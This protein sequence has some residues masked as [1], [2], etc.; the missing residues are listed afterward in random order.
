MSTSSEQKP[1][2]N[3]LLVAITRLGD[4]LQASPTIVGMKE[5]F[6]GARLT[7]L[8]DQQFAAICR[9]IPGIDE[10]Y[11]VDLSM[12]VRSLH[13]EGEG[14]VDGFAYVQ[15]LV[16][17][18][19]SR[20]FDY[21]VNMASA[22]YTALLVK[23]LD[24]EQSRGWTADDE[25]QRIISN[26]WSM[27]FAA[28]VY[29]SNRHYNSINLVDVIR[30]SAGVHAHPRHLVY[31][32]PDK[33]AS[34]PD[35]FLAENGI[36]DGSGPLVC[37][38]AGASQEKRQWAPVKFARLLQLLVEQHGARVIMTGA[39]SEAQIIERILS[40]Y[41][42]PNIANAVGKTNLGELAALLKRADALVTGDTG[43]MHLSVAVGTPVVALFLA[44]A[45]CFETGPYSQGN[46][47]IQPQISCN[48]CNPNF[49]CPRPDCH[50]Q[51]TPDMVAHL[52]ELRLN[53][54]SDQVK[55]L[56]VDERLCPAESV[57]IYYSDFDEE[58]FLDFKRI[59]SPAQRLGYHP[60]YF[61]AAM[62]AYRQL[63]KEEFGMMEPK[64][65]PSVEPLN[66]LAVVDHRSE[67]TAGLE[68]AVKAAA[69][70]IEVSER[71]IELIRDVSSSPHLL[72]EVNNQINAINRHIEDIGLT[73]PM[74]GALVRMFVMERQ[75]MQGKDAALL[76]LDMKEI[77]ENL[78][79]RGQKFAKLFKY[80]VEQNWN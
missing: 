45:Y 62:D 54:P 3:I 53:T 28:F 71:L 34:F 12:V 47:V 14:I 51:I 60:G 72:G 78:R 79:R 6:P 24:I 29:H 77:Y 27:L 64:E 59:N 35:S 8:V 42:H 1:V 13:R 5:Q 68:E 52:L 58:G 40:I 48:P 67:G 4:L 22:G 63:W 41:K 56:K 44:S 21:C 16:S 73:Y 57:A 30:C 37:L 65:V 10:L 11:E 23:M 15:Q 32:V 70:G 7:V 26:P 50:D 9:G 2:S 39:G 36:A 75:N 74:L 43:P 20:N 76:A 31:Q 18:L 33:Y 66:K 49:S 80:N 55:N 61:D 25:G 19:R 38:Q 17:D 69:K 46:I